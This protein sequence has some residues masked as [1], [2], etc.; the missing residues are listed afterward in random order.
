MTRKLRIDGKP[1]DIGPF[2]EDLRACFRKTRG[3]IAVYIYGSY[4]TQDQTPLSDVDLAFVYLP[5]ALPSFDEELEA[6]GCVTAAA[7]ADDVSV[8]TLNR[9]PAPFQF[10][11][12]TTGRLIYCADEVALADF[13]EEILNRHGD[14]VIDHETFL[15][16]YDAALVER[17]GR[18]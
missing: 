8:T 4:G 3:L 12:L 15:R 1:I 6:T 2:M 17:Y 7:N 18:E 13:V 5:D 10:R 9:A 14:Y 16:E 11:V